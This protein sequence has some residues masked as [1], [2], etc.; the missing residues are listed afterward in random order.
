MQLLC[1]VVAIVLFL[2]AAFSVS[3][4]VAL[5]PLGLAFLAAAHLPW[6]SIRTG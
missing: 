1:L 5:L 2:L 6:G 4:P 3:T